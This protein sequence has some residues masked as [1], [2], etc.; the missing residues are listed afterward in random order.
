MRSIIILLLFSWVLLYAW[1]SW[2]K[3]LPPLFLYVFVVIYICRCMVGWMVGWYCVRTRLLSTLQQIIFNAQHLMYVC[4]CLCRTSDF[5][6]WAA[7]WSIDLIYFIYYKRAMFLLFAR[8]R[9]SQ[10]C[11]SH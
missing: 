5:R 11:Q 9:P 4:M 2:F 6:Q 8:N 10:F 7:R 3:I 1:L